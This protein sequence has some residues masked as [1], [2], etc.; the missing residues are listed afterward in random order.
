MKNPFRRKSS[1]GT[2][3]GRGNVKREDSRP[4][5]LRV[6]CRFFPL[7]LVLWVFLILY[8]NPL[9]LAASL[10]RLAAPSVDPAAVESLAVGLPSDPAAIEQEVLRIV[11]YRYDWQ[12]YGMPWYFPTVDEVLKNGAGDCKA[13]AIVLASVLESKGIPYKINSSPTH[14]WVDY[15]GKAANSI[16]NP[17]AGFYEV[18]PDTGAR[19]LSL[20]SINLG[21]AIDTTWNGF[22]PPMPAARKVLLVCGPVILLTVR[23]G[24]PR[25]ARR[26]ENADVRVASL[27]REPSSDRTEV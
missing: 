13:R 4:R 20:P 18:D 23:L 15:E 27:N 26:K 5:A 19:S 14:V 11:P 3:E 8:P 22:W 9:R 25:L 24:W 17:N 12:V 16:E 1:Q 6:F 7:L 21:E 10:G 2:E